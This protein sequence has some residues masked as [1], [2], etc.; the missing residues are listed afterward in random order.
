VRYLN[1][2]LSQEH[3]QIMWNNN[4]MYLFP[5]KVSEINDRID[6]KKVELELYRKIISETLGFMK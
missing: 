3:Q 4:M 2:K 5:V 1:H 6:R